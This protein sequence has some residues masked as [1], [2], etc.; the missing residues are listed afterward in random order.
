MDADWCVEAGELGGQ[1]GEHDLAA[2]FMY[3]SEPFLQT[4][5]LLHCCTHVMF[6]TP[7]SGSCPR[8]GSATLGPQEEKGGLQLTQVSRTKNEIYETYA[9]LLPLATTPPYYSK[10]LWWLTVVHMI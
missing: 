3:F 4:A 10:I 8:S 5:T 1:A 9:Q 7:S 2:F 6:V